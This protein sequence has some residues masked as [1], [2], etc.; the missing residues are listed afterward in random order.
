MPNTQAPI[1]DV[2]DNGGEF[3]VDDGQ[4]QASILEVSDLEVEF[5]VDDGKIKV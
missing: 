2:P 3:A 5:A 4:N 1:L